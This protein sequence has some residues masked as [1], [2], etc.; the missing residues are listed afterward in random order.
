MSG[1]GSRDTANTGK[2]SRPSTPLTDVCG[3]VD[4]ALLLLGLAGWLSLCIPCPYEIFPARLAHLLLRGFSGFLPP[5]G[6][7][8]RRYSFGLR[9]PKPGAHLGCNLRRLGRF[10]RSGGL[11]ESRLRQ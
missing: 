5:L 3:S 6:P 11:Q 1:W 7:G 8:G 4:R 10:L 2:A 9:P